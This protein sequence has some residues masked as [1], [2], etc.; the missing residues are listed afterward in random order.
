M[1]KHIV[2]HF[3][4][5]SRAPIK[6]GIAIYNAYEVN[7]QQQQQK[8]TSFNENKCIFDPIE[9]LKQGKTF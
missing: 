7:L 8:K 1:K 9:S 3:H 4:R 5:L 6:G 2:L